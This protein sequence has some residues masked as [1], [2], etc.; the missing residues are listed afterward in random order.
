M[1]RCHILVNQPAGSSAAVGPYGTWT[2]K[3][4]SWNYHGSVTLMQTS[5][6]IE[7]FPG[8]SRAVD[9]AAMCEGGNTNDRPLHTAAIAALI[10]GRAC[11][12]NNVSQVWRLSRCPSPAAGNSRAPEWIGVMGA[13]VPGGSTSPLSI[14][15]TQTAISQTR[16]S[17]G[18]PCLADFLGGAHGAGSGSNMVPGNASLLFRNKKPNYVPGGNSSREVALKGTLPYIF[19]F[20]EPR[21]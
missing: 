2:E 16:V 21:I 10:S 20:T 5:W 13:C 18:L 15:E 1:A 14:N 11:H 4:A 7:I 12:N 8:Q 9:R 17:R 6:G 3:R 19:H